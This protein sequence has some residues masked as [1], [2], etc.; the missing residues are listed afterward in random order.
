[1]DKELGEWGNDGYTYLHLRN[2]REIL[3]DFWIK[4][5][6]HRAKPQ[7]Y[8][9]AVIVWDILDAPPENPD[10]LSRHTIFKLTA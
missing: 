1:L 8:D 6:T 3:V 10:V 9:G 5:E 7:G 4:G 2:I